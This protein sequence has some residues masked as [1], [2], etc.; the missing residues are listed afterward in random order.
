[1]NAYAFVFV[2]DCDWKLSTSADWN[3]DYIELEEPSKV[4]GHR[5]IDGQIYKIVQTA[6]G[7]LVATR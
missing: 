5:K 4:L 1:M 3:L 2:G 6:D 7:K